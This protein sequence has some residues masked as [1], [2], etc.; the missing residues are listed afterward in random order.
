MKTIRQIADEIGVSKQAVQKRL[1]REPL[2]SC[3]YPYIETRQGTKYIADTGEKLIIEAFSE[4]KESLSIDTGIDMGI[5]A[6]I[7]GDTLVH[8]VVATLQ[9]QLK[10]KDQQIAA[11]QQSLSD[12]THALLE[13]QQTARAAQA[14]HAGTIQQQLVEPAPGEP[15]I[16]AAEAEQEK[17]KEQPTQPKKRTQPKPAPPP[18]RG[19]AWSWPFSK[20]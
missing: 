4:N 7:D 10:V 12:T 6:S 11:L 3:L 8:S 1:A 16:E 9:E 17:P 19:F 20:K 14:L 18:R 2:K 5:D 15:P 13:A